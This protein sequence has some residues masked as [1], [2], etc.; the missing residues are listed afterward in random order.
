[1]AL[2]QRPFPDRSPAPDFELANQ[3]GA[4]V[5]LRDLAGHPAFLVFFPFA[6]SRVCTGELRQ[7]SSQAAIF[8]Q[9]GSRVVGVSCDSRYTLRAYAEAEGLPFDLLSDF[10]PH[11]EVSRLFGAFDEQLGRPIRLTAVIRPDGSLAETFST[12]PGEARP[13]AAYGDALGR[14]A[15]APAAPGAVT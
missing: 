5:R 14:L 8:E 9:A 6:F 3:H 7:L 13:P 1:M 15:A 10:W 2:D 11:G 12:G 4:P